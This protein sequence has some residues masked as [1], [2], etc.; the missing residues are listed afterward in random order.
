MFYD[1]F[2]TKFGWKFKREDQ[3]DLTQT[4]NAPYT[5]PIDEGA[6]HVIGNNQWG[7]NSYGLS[8]DQIFVNEN[9]LIL[10]YRDISLQPEPNS[11]V[12]EIV[13]EIIDS[14]DRDGPVSVIVDEIE[15]PKLSA[16]IREEFGNIISLLNF[17]ENC[18]DLTRKWYVDGRLYHH[19]IIDENNSKA[20]IQELR[21]ISPLQIKKVREEKEKWDLMV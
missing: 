13:N 12:N 10:K 11:A 21:Y 8:I 7:F 3:N 18:Y 19:I 1:Q 6:A 15:S 16:I 20:G 17:N 2:L 9:D 4:I 14:D 5:P